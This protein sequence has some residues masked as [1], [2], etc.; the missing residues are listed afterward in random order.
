MQSFLENGARMTRGAHHSW[1]QFVAPGD[2]VVDATCGNGYDTLYLASLVGP[3]GQVYAFD[4]QVYHLL[5]RT[6]LFGSGL[7]A[8]ACLC[9][10]E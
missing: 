1:T 9:T 6:F 4:I 8:L 3:Q 7:H 10:P 5:S 2:T